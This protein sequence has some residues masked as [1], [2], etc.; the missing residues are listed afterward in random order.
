MSHH[1]ATQRF[2]EPQPVK[3]GRPLAPIA[4]LAASLLAMGLTAAPPAPRAQA[5]QEAPAGKLRLMTSAFQAGGEIPS[6]F[7]CEGADVSPALTWNEPPAGT[8]S[9]MLIADDPDAPGGTFTHWLVYD[10]PA[11]LRRL[12]EGVPTTGEIQGGGRQGTNDF[13][14]TGYAGP[15]PPPGKAHRYFFRLYALDE[16]VGL[17]SAATRQELEPAMRGHVLA[18]SEIMGR[19]RR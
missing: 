17:H 6:K 14:K 2:C 10:L 1:L 5:Q 4:W 12:P 15:C 19:F 7:T 18:Q 11:S 9:F 13:P 8:R 16:K 3:T